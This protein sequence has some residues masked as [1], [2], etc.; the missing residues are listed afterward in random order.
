MLKVLSSFSFILVLLVGCDSEKK[1][2]LNDI[3]KVK[4]ELIE[5]ETLKEGI[6]YSIKLIN[7]SD[8]VSF[9]MKEGGKCL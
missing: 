2:T 3:Q 9:M 8:Y 5:K 7:D 4:L 6:S 1:F